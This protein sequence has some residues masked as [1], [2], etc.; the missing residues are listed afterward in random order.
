MSCTLFVHG[1]YSDQWQV[2]LRTRKRTSEVPYE[3]GKCLFIPTNLPS[4]D[5]LCSL[6]TALQYEKYCHDN[7]V[8]PTFTYRCVLL[9]LLA[10]RFTLEIYIISYSQPRLKKCPKVSPSGL[11]SA[12]MLAPYIEFALAR[13]TLGMCLEY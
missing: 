9:E 2:F 13:R 1:L 11:R 12:F 7:S 4:H 8:F 5:G 6:D 10:Q 3:D